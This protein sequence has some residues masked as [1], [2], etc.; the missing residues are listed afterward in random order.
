MLST[1]TPLFQGPLADFGERLLLP[2]QVPAT[3]TPA[4]QLFTAEGLD[5]VLK[6]YAGG[7]RTP[8]RWPPDRRAVMS[9]WSKYFLSQAIYVPVAANLL[10]D[11]QLPLALDQLGLLLDEQSLVTTLVVPNEGERVSGTDGESRLRPLMDATLAP[12]IASMAAHTGIAPRALWSNV[13]HYYAYLI[14]RLRELPSPPAAVDE[15]ARLMT[16]RHFDD[17]A[18]NPLYRP[19]RQVIDAAGEARCVRRVCCVRYRL[20]ELGYCGNCPLPAALARR[21]EEA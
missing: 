14:D 7:F 6:R 9:Q 13:G 4:R 18:R 8:G 15:G 21:P 1:L 16:L 10:L 2:H 5:A 11:R 20:P 3:P 17:G 12:A 19:I